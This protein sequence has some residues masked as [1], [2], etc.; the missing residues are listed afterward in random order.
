MKVVSQS[1]MIIEKGSEP[2]RILADLAPSKFLFGFGVAVHPHREK[3]ESG[4]GL[5]LGAAS[6]LAG[7]A[8]AS[9]AGARVRLTGLP[10][11]A[12]VHRKKGAEAANACWFSRCCSSVGEEER[13]RGGAGTGGVGVSLVGEAKWQPPLLLL[14]MEE[15]VGEERGGGG[16]G[17]QLEREETKRMRIRLRLGL[18][19]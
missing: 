11:R 7:A 14:L 13:R 18:L 19:I 8:L 2:G 9:A 1:E 3:E 15:K 12:A 16:G 6:L 17:R 5:L 10:R 4:A